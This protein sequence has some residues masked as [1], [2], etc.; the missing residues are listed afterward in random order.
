M[1]NRFLGRFSKDIGIDLGTAN[2]LIYIRDKGIVVNEPSVVAVNL[3]TDQILAVGH[4]AKDMVGKTPPHILTARPLVH[5]VISDFEITEKMLKYFIERIH[6]DTFAL[7]PRPRV[8]IGVPID[9]TEVERKAV[10]DAVLSAGAREVHVVEEPMAAAIGAR[11]PIEDPVASLIVD[12]GGGRTEVAVI[13]LSGVVTWKSIAIAGDELNKNIVQYAREAFG[14]YLGERHAEEVKIKI[15]SAV[16][17]EKPMEFPLRGRDVLTGLPKEV[18][19]NDS[20]IREAVSRSLRTVI[21]AIKATLEITPPELVADIH[22]R[23]MVLSGGGALLRGL[24]QLIT[25]ETEIPVRVT[26]EPLTCVV[27]GTGLLLDAPELLHT[28]R[29]PSARETERIG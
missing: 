4:E 16:P 22:E 27:R 9:V 12:I 5:G 3:R 17:L 15:G 1:L 18:I 11:L 25:G 7:V 20:Q 13:S 10:E 2:T 24:D 6:K 26:D 14:L 29:L 28:V 21:E 19:V 8:V 23:G